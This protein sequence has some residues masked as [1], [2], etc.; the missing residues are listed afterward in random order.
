VRFAHAMPF[1]AE[2]REDGVR[3][4]LWAP[5]AR[6][7]DLL[8][9]GGPAVD[10]A[11][12]GDGWFE[13]TTDEAAA[14]TRYAYRIDG[15][16]AVPDPASRAQPDDVHDP[17]A[18]IDPQGYRW[19]QG[20][21]RGR[22]WYEAVV[23]ELHV[24]TFSP[25]G[26]FDGVR[27][28][29]DHLVDLGVTAI[30]L[31]PI[32]A[33]PGR[34]N[35]GYDGVLP[36]AP[37]ATCGTP[38]DLKRLVDAAHERGLM[39][40]LDVVYNHFGPEGN[41]LHLYAPQFFDDRVETPWGAAIDYSRRE[42]RDF[43]VHNALY[44]LQEYRFDGLRLDAVH[45]IVD[46]SDTHL[47]DELAERVRRDVGADRHVHLILENEHNDAHR[48]ER[49]GD[50]RPVAYT[51]QWNDDVHHACHVLATGERA[52]YYA[53]YAERP[54]EHLARCLSEGFAYQGEPYGPRGGEPRGTPSA[55]LPPTAFVAF[56]QNHDQI[57]NRA[58]G[59]RLTLLSEPRAL[60]ALSAIVLLAP[61]VPMLF[62]GEEWGAREP[63]SFF[64]DFHDELADA[65]HEGRRRE[66]AHFPEFVSDEARAAIPDPNAEETFLRSRLDWERT[67]EGE[68]ADALDRHR[69]LLA[70]RRRE[71]VP[72]IERVRP[73]AARA[74]LH[75][76]GGLSLR[77][78]LD[79]GSELWLRANLSAERCDRVPEG[80]TER[81]LYAHGDGVGAALGRGELP[82][83]SVAW[84][85]APRSAS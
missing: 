46:D 33:F 48:L 82:P 38:D 4:R 28:R 73:G 25:E 14:G 52:G 36:F 5:A 43:A 72:L 55:R 67:G 53:G 71:I 26:S 19:R 34:R 16:R 10:M 60:E 70:L 58:F 65:V 81:L 35:W 2:L 6:R 69:E 11:A 24:G 80:P 85:V 1:G 40:I 49:S 54:L 61:H 13:T 56:L 41:Y 42:V 57:G 3:F 59:E 27:A 39:M 23:Y 74:E 64:C 20:A 45:A 62:M 7:V 77:W 63:F 22:P 31:M 44:W 47:L 78:P 29:L 66:F 21:W 84:T 30:E 18:V 32:A 15:G 83:W 9:R 68:H 50:A 12:V 76:P 37:D 79:D 17:S 51:A 8:L 75:G